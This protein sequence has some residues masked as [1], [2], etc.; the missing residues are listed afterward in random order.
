MT[1]ITQKGQATIPA[2]TR[3]FLNLKPHQKVIFIKTKN[4]VVI[5]PAQSFLNL[6]GSIKAKKKFTDKEA[7]KKILRHV[8]QTYAQKNTRT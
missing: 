2:D 4:Q 5:K 3:K 1:T 8:G 7:D 6:K